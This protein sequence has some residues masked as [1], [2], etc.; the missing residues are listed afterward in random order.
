MIMETT[1]YSDIRLIV[2]DVDGVF[3]N[4]KKIYS[5]SGDVVYKE[6]YDKDF[7]ALK[8]L[9]KYFDIVILSGDDRVNKV[10]FKTK[11]IPFYHSRNKGKKQL[12]KTILNKHGIGP[13]NCMF[14]GDDLPD[15]PCFR[16]IPISMCPS[17][18]VKDVK[19]L[20][21]K[22]F[23]AKG[24]NGVIVELYNE[25]QEEIMLRRKYGD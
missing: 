7:T 19:L 15:I 23:K 1:T 24:G 14:I 16:L 9:R 22:I 2:L 12:I 11:G 21:Y 6:F 17:D 20:S 4:G 3:T 25:M 10:L 5:L 8:E 13:D 18:A